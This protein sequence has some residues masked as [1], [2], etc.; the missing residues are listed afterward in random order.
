MLLVLLI[1]VF[2]SRRMEFFCCSGRRVAATPASKGCRDGQE[3]PPHGADGGLPSVSPGQAPTDSAAAAAA[4]TGPTAVP[5]TN[6]GR[7]VAVAPAALGEYVQRVGLHAVTVAGRTPGAGEMAVGP[8]FL[9]PWS[10]HHYILD[11]ATVVPLGAT[12]GITTTGCVVAPLARF[13]P[14]PLLG[15]DYGSPLHWAA[16][17]TG[18][19]EA[20]GRAS[21]T[22]VGTPRPPPGLL[23]CPIH[24][25]PGGGLSPPLAPELVER[26]P[27]ALG[28]VSV[29]WQ[30]A[31]GGC[32]PPPPG[33]P[34]PPSE[35][36]AKRP[37]GD[38][39]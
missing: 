5:C 31:Q 21:L 39:M 17:A 29:P 33:P 7:L 22:T 28:R 27:E 1:K 37:R 23:Q 19:A 18:T 34:P 11:P 13:P 24:A 12:L 4:E 15:L 10:G 20:G 26:A 8:F 14:M 32:P 3:Q 30:G 38:S 35:R 25:V 6:Q 2:G 16:A 36:R 9:D